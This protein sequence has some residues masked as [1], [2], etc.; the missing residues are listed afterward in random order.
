MENISRTRIS[1][2]LP[3]DMVDKIDSYAKSMN[4]NRTAAITVLCNQ[5]LEYSDIVSSLPS[6]LELAKKEEN[7]K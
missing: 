1:L 2:N 3:S 6:L 7:S 5:A 4:I